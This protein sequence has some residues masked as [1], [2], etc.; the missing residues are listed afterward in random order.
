MK[1]PLKCITFLF[2]VLLS[3]M[4]RAE[5]EIIVVG[6]D[7]NYPPYEFLNAKGVPDG[8]NTELTNAIA[9]VMGLDIKV[10]LGRWDEMKASFDE[11]S[12]DILQGISY[13]ETRA[14]LIEFSPPHSLIHHSLFARKGSAQITSISDLSGKSIILQNGGIMS[15]ELENSGLEA[16]FIYV[17]THVAALRL[18]ASGKHDYAIVANLPGLYL[19]K[20]LAL[21][22][23]EPVGQLFDSQRYGYGVLK[24]NDALLAQFNEGLAILKNTG[25]QQEIYNK[26]FGTNTSLGVKW[27]KITVYLVSSS[28]ILFAIFGAVMVWNRSL[29]EQVSRRT[30]ALERQQQQLIQADKMT[31]LG[32]LV[33]GVA[34]EI[35]NP[36]SLLLLNLPVLKES[37]NDIEDILEE[38]YQTY[39]DFELAG[40][41]YSR[42]KNELP[43]MLCD[44]LEG[45]QHIRRIVD[46]LKDFARKEPLELTEFVDF[47]QVI[48]AAIRLTDR[49]IRSSTDHFSVYYDDN[50]PLLKGSAQRLQQVV[51]NLIVNACQA[52]DNHSQSITINTLYEPKK[53]RIRISVED[54]GVGIEPKNINSLSDP[55]FTTKREQGGTGLGL[56]ISSTIVEEHGGQ[57]LF[58]SKLSEGTE[59]IVYLPLDM[60]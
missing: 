60:E 10:V 37:F 9:D 45:T 30:K 31:S 44:M 29:A 4:I 41:R 51:I 14:R 40:L 43:V 35:N 22:N 8:Y 11:G 49:T 26:W 23:I 59:A 21:S 50:L 6:G 38:H 33:S 56:S 3:N 52:L 20:E 13:S 48:A 27:E 47:N 42:M 55:F 46:D 32:I 39:G 24:G 17:D 53:N 54:T 57:L 1:Y 15:E 28:I 19:G 16:E 2:L 18:L 34:H 12:I 36:T 58:K 5:D 25:K 7:H